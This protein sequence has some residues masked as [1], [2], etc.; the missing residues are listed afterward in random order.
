MSLTSTRAIRRAVRIGTTTFVLTLFTLNIASA[1][2]P[3]T[4]RTDWFHDAKWGVFTHYLS[5]IALK[6]AEPTVEAW[7]KAVDAFDVEGLAKQI[8]SIGAKYYV[9]TLGQN[10]GY[11]LSPNA[12]YDQFVGIQPSKCSKRDLVADLYAALN[13]KGV[14]LMVYLPAGAPD[15]DTV[16]M[17]SLGWKNGKYPI[18]SHANGGPDGGDD[19]LI[20]FQKKWEA[21]IREWSTRW[22]TKVCGWW[23]D[24]CYFP[25]AM[26]Q[27]PDAPN[28]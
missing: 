6:G 16:A 8:E 1:Q 5:D 24:G 3:A 13:P 12:T 27:H 26:Y 2:A 17:A 10:S 7:N 20:E 28:F 23:F 11:Y 4:H 9:I 25:V 15:R 22:G 19:R 14:K 21:V 18:W